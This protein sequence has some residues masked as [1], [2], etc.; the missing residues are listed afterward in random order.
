MSWNQ[1]PPGHANCAKQGSP[2]K[3]ITMNSDEYI[4]VD[5][6]TPAVP[7]RSEKCCSKLNDERMLLALSV[8]M[9][10]VARCYYFKTPLPRRILTRQE[11]QQEV[12]ASCGEGGGVINFRYK[13][14]IVQLKRA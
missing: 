14:T 12:D 5:S 3:D 6:N 7:Q 1:Y 2:C 8:H 10:H 4:T 11:A 9:H 13:F